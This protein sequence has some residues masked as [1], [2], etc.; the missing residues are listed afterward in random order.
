MAYAQRL[1]SMNENEILRFCVRGIP[2]MHISITVSDVMDSWLMQLCAFAHQ[3]TD[4]EH[5]WSRGRAPPKINDVLWD[6]LHWINFYI[7]S[8]KFACWDWM[9]Q[10]TY[11]PKSVKPRQTEKKNIYNT[12]PV[13]KDRHCFVIGLGFPGLGRFFTCFLWS[14]LT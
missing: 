10:S 4:T 14:G 9:C 7:M 12:I 13:S 5:L 3:D 6:Q 8:T 2:C 11:P 1:W